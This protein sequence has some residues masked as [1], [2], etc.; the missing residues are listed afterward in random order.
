MNIN[1]IE[2][3]QLQRAV[4]IACNPDA[5]NDSNELFLASAALS[6]KTRDAAMLLGVSGKGSHNAVRALSNYCANKGAAV[7]CRKAG[8][9][10]RAQ[11]YEAICERIFNELPAALR[12]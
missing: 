8:T 10:D 12:W 7:V 5:V 4:E 1:R 11:M 2:V 3:K 6:R 9:I